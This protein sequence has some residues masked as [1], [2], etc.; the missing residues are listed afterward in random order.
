MPLGR[1]FRYFVD[2][3]DFLLSPFYAAFAYFAFS[4]AM[5]RFH[6]AYDFSWITLIYYADARHMDIM[7]LLFSPVI[8]AIMMPMLWRLRHVCL[9]ICH[10]M[11]YVFRLSLLF[12]APPLFMF[13]PRWRLRCYFCRERYLFFDAAAV[14][15]YAAVYATA[16]IDVFTTPCFFVADTLLL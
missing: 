15:C 13:S 9:L 7:P 4:R 6:A 5:I 11:S 8:I 12:F 3:F 1:C 2:G 16:L 10:A 14:S